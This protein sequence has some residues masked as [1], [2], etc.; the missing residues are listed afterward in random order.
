MSNDLFRQSVLNRLPPMPPTRAP[1]A[2]GGEDAD[3]M[4]ELAEEEE[5]LSDIAALPG[6]GSTR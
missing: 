5:G 4:E 2:E 6:Q 1:W 3:T